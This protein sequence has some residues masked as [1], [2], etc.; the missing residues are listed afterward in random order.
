VQCVQIM[1]ATHAYLMDVV[2]AFV[3][4]DIE[5]VLDQEEN[6]CPICQK[7]FDNVLCPNGDEEEE[8]DEN[9]MHESSSSSW[10]E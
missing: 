6:K 2:I 9:M 8:D 7:H 4:P 10:E 5:H 3:R 1:C